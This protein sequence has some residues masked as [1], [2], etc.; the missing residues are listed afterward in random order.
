MEGRG[1]TSDWETG[2]ICPIFKKGDKLDCN[3]YR[4]ITLLDTA[5]K[6]FSNILNERLKKVTENL[7]GDYHCGFCK[8][9]STIDQIFTIRQMAE[10]HYE[11]N[12]DLHMLYV[13]FKQAFNS[14]HTDRHKLY[15]AM[16]D[17][18]IPHKLIRLVKMMMM[19][20]MNQ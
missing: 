19:M 6:V 17:M 7:L 11:H 14:R 12:Q 5:Y 3:N 15:Q 20:M 1:D 8:D 10:K 13:D 4:G 16:E 9:R 2:N 18:K